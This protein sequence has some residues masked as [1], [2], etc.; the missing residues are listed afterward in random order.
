[1]TVPELSQVIA[2][3]Q[4]ALPSPEPGADKALHNYQRRIRSLVHATE[5]LSTYEALPREAIEQLHEA[6][7]ESAAALAEAFSLDAE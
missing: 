1:M 6:L 3:I 7:L 2:T 5:S 4:G